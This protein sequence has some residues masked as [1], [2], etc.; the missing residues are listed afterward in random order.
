MRFIDDLASLLTPWGVPPAAA[1]LYGYLLLCEAPASLDAMA[2]DLEIS[3][4][5]ASLSAR[6]LELYGLVRRHSTRGSRRIL[7]AASDDF[8]GILA[9]QTQLLSAMAVR[10]TE[11]AG[12]AT[13]PPVT[14]RLTRMAAFYR[15]TGDDLMRIL[16]AR[17]GQPA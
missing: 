4:S 9:A 11:G 6:R 8:A 2:A 12:L 5:S 3:K 13:A 1:R 16:G 10:L 7:Y 17:L 15:Q 14:A